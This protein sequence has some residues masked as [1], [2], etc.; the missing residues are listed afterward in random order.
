MKPRFL[1]EMEEAFAC[2]QHGIVNF[3]VEDRFFFPEKDIGPTNL[4]YFTSSYFTSI[5]YRTAI[6]SPSQ[7][8][9][10]LVPKSGQCQA[11][12]G[13]NSQ[14]EPIAMFNGIRSLLQSKDEKWLVVVN[15]SERIA[16]ATENGMVPSG[17]NAVFSEILH[18]LGRDPRIA[19]G[20]SRLILITYSGLPDGLLVNSP[21]YRTIEV[22]LPSYEERLA[23]LRFLNGGGS[24]KAPLLAR[25]EDDLS[26]E[27]IARQTKGMPLMDIEILFRAGKHYDR[28]ISNRHIRRAKAAALKKLGRDILRLLEPKQ[29]LES[30]AGLY[31]FK[32]F[33]EELVMR[34]K[35]GRED[36]PQSL[37][38]QG[39]PG[40]AK[41]ASARALA[42]E[43][44]WPLVMPGTLHGPYVGQSEQNL[45]RFITLV[46]QLL[47]VILFF[48]EVDQLIGRRETG[49][50][51]DSGTSQRMLAR[52]YDWMGEGHMRGKIIILGATNRPDLLDPATLDR[53]GISIPF[54]RPGIEEFKE[55]L[56][57]MLDRFKREMSRDDEE[58]ARETISDLMLSGRSFQEILL[59]AGRFAD[60][61]AGSFGGRI[62]KEHIALAA[63]N[64]IDRE[65]PVEMEF[66]ELIAISLAYSQDLLPW[67][68]HNGLRQGAEVPE[69]FLGLGVVESD[70]RLNTARLYQ[71]LGEIK[72]QRYQQRMMR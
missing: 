6:Y 36:L 55:L 34:F 43:L 62:K 11:I 12:K 16:H 2:Q 38:L 51:G 65:D 22:P 58:F 39:V 1:N 40:V 33:L 18:S 41:S 52:I 64:H 9:S 61:E 17:E 49:P 69:R 42:G 31:T 24:Q 66:I 28:P 56:P 54:L 27:E 71:V 48:D 50:S 70:G 5:G 68:D 60:R 7:G 53:F 46:E 15:Y 44:G 25:I 57:I 67:N 30:I 14:G 21:A 23:F 13:I 35:T 63:A 19:A 3:N 26:L 47:P 8:I 45:E 59:A 72:Y 37:I 29:G 32:S 4:T 10:E 20:D